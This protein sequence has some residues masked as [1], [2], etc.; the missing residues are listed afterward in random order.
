MVDE[1]HGRPDADISL[2]FDILRF[3]GICSIVFFHARPEVTLETEILNA[4]ILFKTYASNGFLRAALPVLTAISGYLL[5]RSRL[6]EHPWRLLNRKLRTLLVP[7]VLWNALVALGI[8][9]VQWRS[10]GEYTFSEQLYPFD[11]ASWAEALFALT[12][13]P[14]DYPL[15]FLRDVFMLAAT[16]IVVGPLL[17]RAPVLTLAVASFVFAL[18]LEVWLVLRSYMGV[19]FFLG[20][21]LAVK[22]WDLRAL[23]RWAWPLLGIYTL[24]C[25]AYVTVIRDEQYLL[26]L[27]L[28]G[29]VALFAFSAVLERSAVGKWLASLAPASFFIFASHAII[30]QAFWM[31][32]QQFLSNSLPPIYMWMVAP[33]LTIVVAIG[34]FWVLRRISPSLLMAFTGSRGEHRQ[35]AR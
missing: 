11:A 29:L 12:G 27:R 3:L 21:F 17:V 19:A 28:F 4:S 22:G 5:F 23:D 35:R 25:L 2:R 8:C 14:A 31:P 33:V 34:A 13:A 24:V 32:Y 10:M 7:M 20:G 9:F 1:R 30:L 15:S 18:N 16:A 26:A 6:F